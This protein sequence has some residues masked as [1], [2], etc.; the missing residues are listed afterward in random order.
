MVWP[1][2]HCPEH[3]TDP[4]QAK[5]TECPGGLDEAHMWQGVRDTPYEAA[6]TCDFGEICRGSMVRGMTEYPF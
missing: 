4:V 3:H 5:G 2:G 6:G 1:P